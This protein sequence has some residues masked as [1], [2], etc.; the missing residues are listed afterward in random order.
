MTEIAS[1]LQG[2]PR[3]PVQEEDAI[4]YAG[5]YNLYCDRTSLKQS[6][7]RKLAP[8]SRGRLIGEYLR[9]LRRMIPI[10][11]SDLHSLALIMQG[12][13]TELS[14]AARQYLRKCVFPKIIPTSEDSAT[15]KAEKAICFRSFQSNLIIADRIDQ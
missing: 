6:E 10:T 9:Q 8:L 14:E 11:H 1:V 12:E 13:H 5:L 7:V 4:N 3:S 15:V 2:L